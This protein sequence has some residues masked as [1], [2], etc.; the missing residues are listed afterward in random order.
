VKKKKKMK[1]MT[2]TACEQQPLHVQLE[3]EDGGT[4]YQVL[5]HLGEVGL[6]LRLDDVEGA[7]EAGGDGASVGDEGPQEVHLAV[8]GN[9]V[10]KLLGRHRG[11]CP[12]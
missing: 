10:Q 6:V 12:L 2:T 11:V 5:R 7:G 3:V 8:H 4:A 1:K 9:Q